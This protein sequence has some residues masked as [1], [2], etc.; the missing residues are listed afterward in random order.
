MDTAGSAKPVRGFRK[1]SMN[2]SERRLLERAL[3]F[4][5]M[6]GNYIGNGDVDPSRPD[7]LGV[8]CDLIIDIKQALD[9]SP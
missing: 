4:L 5:V 3:P 2:E 7:S 8:R 9:A 6:L 1:D